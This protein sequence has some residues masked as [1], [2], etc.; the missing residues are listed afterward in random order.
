MD[1]FLG[2]LTFYK[3]KPDSRELTRLRGEMRAVTVSGENLKTPPL[4]LFQSE[5][6]K[7]GLQGLRNIILGNLRA[8]N[9]SASHT[10]A[11]AIIGIIVK[12]AGTGRERSEFLRDALTR[13]R[14]VEVSHFY[15]MPHLAGTEPL[16][17]DGFTMGALDLP[18]LRSRCSR[19]QSN[20]AE[21]YSERQKGR[22][23]LQSPEFSRVVIDFLTPALKVGL[24]GSAAGKEVILNY[25]EH[26]AE[27]H[28]QAMWDE[29]EQSQLFGAPFGASILDAENLRT[30]LGGLA[31][32]VT[33]YLEVV[34]SGAGYVVPT[35]GAFFLNQPGP[36]SDAFER[37]SEHREKYRVREIGDSELG[38]IL[39]TICGFCR[40]AIRLSRS[41]RLND[42]ALYA[43]ICLEQLFSE[44]QSTSKAIASRTACVTHLRM[45]STYKAAEDEV[46]K[47]YDARS[48]FVH[49]GKSV[50][51]EQTERLIE[52]AKEV[53]RSLLVLHMNEENRKEGFLSKWQRDIDFVS[54]G[55]DANRTFENA[56]LADIGIFRS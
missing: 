10:I 38:R 9:H 30:S 16:I 33:I 1:D 18:V 32:K 41:G 23:T 35:E 6:T 3:P 36:D 20:Y 37:F 31:K 5:P 19:A 25:F 53:I 56:F 21:L 55:F 48:K 12:S 22:I 52:F 45:A 54:A 4:D 47:L 2:S 8:A 13:F 7:I 42:A 15:I 26:L 34:R 17:I 11:D 28:F 50:T 24:M 40:E 14:T 43:T 46:L 27:S 39:H 49:A 29:L 44:K 51:F